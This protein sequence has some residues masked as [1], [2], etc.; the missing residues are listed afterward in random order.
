MYE[1]SCHSRVASGVIH[2][3]TYGPD[4][5]AFDNQKV[6]RY[7]WCHFEQYIYDVINWNL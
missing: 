7:V 4:P 3:I 6:S 2:H 5:L 1:V